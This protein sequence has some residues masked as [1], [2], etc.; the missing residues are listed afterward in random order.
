MH[1][2]TNWKYK[3]FLEIIITKNIYM[4]FN[5]VAEINADLYYSILHYLIVNK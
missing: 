5:G 3:L 2:L 4:Y 1:I